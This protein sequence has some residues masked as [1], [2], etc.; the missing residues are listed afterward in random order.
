MMKNK[1]LQLLI[2]MAAILGGF[3]RIYL[4]QHFLPDVLAGALLGS[5]SGILAFYLAQNRISI[6][7]TI[8]KM[9][10]VPSGS[11]SSPG[12]MQTA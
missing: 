7:R 5:G 3:S 12:V 10:R 6:K 11:V 8:K 4:A 2:L 1:N 9:H